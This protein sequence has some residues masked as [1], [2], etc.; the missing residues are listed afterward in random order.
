[1]NQIAQDWVDRTFAGQT[2]EV[3]DVKGE[4]YSEEFT[5]TIQEKSVQQELPLK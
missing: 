1:M 4:D 3:T 2:L 5:I